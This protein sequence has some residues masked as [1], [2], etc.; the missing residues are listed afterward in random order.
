MTTTASPTP[1]AVRVDGRDVFI[2]AGEF[3]YFRLGRRQWAPTLQ[4]LRAAHLNAVTVSAPWSWHEPEEGEFDLRGETDER[5]DLAGALEL[6]SQHDLYVIFRPGPHVGGHWRYGGIPEWLLRGHPEVL[7][8]DAQGHAPSLDMYCPP[9]SYQHPVY[10]AYVAGWYQGFLPLLRRSLVTEQGPVI[11]VQIDDRPSY[12]WGLQGGDPLFVDYNPW[13]VGDGA[14]PGLYQRWLAAHYGDVGH[15]NARYGTRYGRFEEVQPPRRPPAS[16]R[17]LPWFSDWRRCKM[18]LLNQHLEY[19]Y[20]WLHQGGVDVPIIILYP[21]QSPLAARRCA[22]HFR[23]RGRPVLVA[24]AADAQPNG[25]RRADELPLGQAV[26][27]AELA[28]RW[29]K[30]TPFTPANLETPGIVSPQAPTDG[31]E[32]LSV[33]Q[34]GHGL[35][36]LGFAPMVGSEAPAGLGGRSYDRGAPIG[37]RGDLRPHYTAIQRLGQFLALH[38]ER[39]LRTEPLADLCFGWYEPYEDCAQ[40][41]DTRALGWRDDYRDMLYARFG[42]YGDGSRGEGS[43]LSLMSMAGLNYAMLDLERDPLEEWLT[44]PQLWV[45]GLDFMAA[46]VQQDLISYVKAGGHLVM[47][48]RVPQLD[49]ALQ[50]CRL[51]EALFPA[52]PLRPQPGWPS[53]HRRMPLHTVTLEPG[54]DLTVADYVDTFDLP[55]TC[56]PVAWEG[57][58]LRPCAYRTV[59]G[60]GSATLLGFTPA[61]ASDGQLEHKRFLNELANQAGVRRHATSDALTLHVVERATAAGSDDPAGYLFVVNPY[62]WPVRSRLSYLDPRTHQPAVLPRLLKGVEFSGQG[63]LILSLE[64]PIPQTGLVI[65]YTTSQVQG[66]SVDGDRVLLTLYGQPGTMGETAF[67]LPAAGGNLSLA[68]PVRSERLRQEGEELLVVT[69][70]HHHGTAIIRFQR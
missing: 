17:E 28:R 2:F 48:P 3:P 4:R 41:G 61:P 63:G 33:L 22:D 27:M 30:G 52:R 36:A 21:Y 55:P 13:V 19:L 68:S 39:L 11:A 49:E 5:R 9:I 45:A 10:E 50:P 34:L 62:G 67:R 58:S 51:L 23:L 14:R 20:D 1:R 65:V 64:T 38:G 57:R 46:T 32:A 18:D 66:W 40:Q 37:R 42:L 8:L 35:N 53:G 6:C 60:R 59:H 44:Y 31:V 25:A 70:P 15:L 54:H 69:Y 7:A 47:L 16:H 12:W 24:H 29:V 26:G 43:L 56:Q